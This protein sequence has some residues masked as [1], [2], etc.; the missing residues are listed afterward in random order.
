MPA[1]FNERVTTT[2]IE[3][4]FQDDPV[5][6]G[7]GSSV[8]D[9]GQ[10]L[11]VDAESEG[12]QSVLTMPA[13]FNERVTTTVIE[14]KFQDDPVRG[15]TGSS[16][17]DDGQ[18]LGVNAESEG[19]ESVATGP[20]AVAGADNSVAL[21]A[22]TEVLEAF[23][24]AFGDRDML[25]HSDRNIKLPDDA[26]LQ[27]LSDVLITDE[28][29]EGETVGYTLDIDGDTALSVR[30]DADGSGGITDIRTSIVG[31]LLVDGE[32]VQ[33]DTEVTGTI[34]VQD[35]SD[36]TQFTLDA[37]E[38][39]PL[40]DWHENDLVRVNDID[41][42]SLSGDLVDR[43]E[44][45][46][47]LSGNVYVTEE[48][49][50]DPTEHEGDLWIQIDPRF[51]GFLGDD[52]GDNRVEDR[53][54]AEEVFY[55]GEQGVF[56]PEYT[57]DVGTAEATNDRLVL[58][59]EDAIRTE[60]NLDLSNRVVWEWQGVDVTE[61][62]DS[63]NILSLNLWSDSTTRD[64][65]NRLGDGYL[66]EA[67]PTEGYVLVKVDDGTTE[68]LLTHTTDTDEVVDIKVV[69]S[70]GGDF[71]F[72][73]DGEVIGEEEDLDNTDPQYTGFGKAAAEDTYRVN[74][75]TVE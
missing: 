17:E 6:G 72:R 74:R 43:E 11:G 50:D 10:A 36:T 30:A 69:R 57:L 26:D 35:G 42:N 55:K 14:G 33:T 44:P 19:T 12:T 54:D 52:W 53:L 68:D 13:E 65:D 66:V 73:V 63:D 51:R 56:R 59:G 31:E 75:L 34:E 40:A 39:S 3:G 60:I 46:T 32:T 5:R 67:R 45:V 64:G 20:S 9:D 21:G 37:T 23:T 48:E 16:V 29:E 4:K 24:F 28:V 47:N 8:E 49:E 2:V 70:S 25:L 18:A 22:N 62:E 1:E 58:D 15:G 41:L 71:S 61:S 7:T 27:S 38:S